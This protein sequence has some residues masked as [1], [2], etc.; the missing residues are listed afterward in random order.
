MDLD[1]LDYNLPK[2]L[3]AL[4]PVKPRDESNLIINNKIPKIVR[5][6]SIL[7]ELNA[8][9][10]IILNNTKVLLSDFD[11][12]FK[13]KKISI[14]LNKLEDKIRNIWSVF[15]KAKVQIFIG[16]KILVFDSYH[17][18]VE[19]IFNSKGKREIYLKFNLSVNKL[20]KKIEEFGRTPLPPYIKKRGHKKSDKNDYQTVFAKK[21][22][23]VAAPTAS[24]HFTK[25]LIS[26]LLKKKIKIIFITL[27]VNGGTYLPIR[28]KKVLEHEMYF[29]YGYIS[30]K[31][32][33]TINKIK[34]T[35]GRIIAVGTTVLRLLE[36]SKDNE[37]NIR[38][39]KGET[40]LFIKPGYEIN[41][42]DG[43]ITNFHTPK[44]TL[45]LIIFCLI[46]K[47]STMEL[48]RFAIK[49]KLSFFSYGDAWL[50]WNKSD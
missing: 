14:N 5:F 11:G 3:I 39:F 48:Y 38:P 28:N 8:G 4:Y 37:G 10:A 44:S 49:K 22:G 1:D 16:D 24:L 43:L 42:I 17:A 40:N 9:D 41:T 26:K 30:K 18:H 23:A 29:E 31:S 15:I 13:K 33:D 34:S 19:K 25:N 20:K 21:E 36:S 12:F 27:H 46:G 47:E 2:E 50:I 45:L 6:K 35:G 32:A 7:K